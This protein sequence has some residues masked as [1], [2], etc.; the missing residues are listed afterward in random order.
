MGT[1][2]EWSYLSNEYRIR[3]R[4]DYDFYAP[5]EYD[6]SLTLE[7][8]RNFCNEWTFT[9]LTDLCKEKLKEN[10]F[11]DLIKD[12]IDNKK[13]YLRD[14]AKE[15]FKFADDNNIPIYVL[16]AGLGNVIEHVMKYAIPQYQ[17]LLNKNLLVIVS[18][19]LT[20]DSNSGYI[21]GF[22]QPVLNTFSKVDVS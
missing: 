22:K 2:C 6:L 12:V 19:F 9:E 21:N 16:S 1:V 7:E 13:L 11:E 14:H 4:K 17:S 10:D 15:I 20:F 3:R 8:R 5:K 18:N